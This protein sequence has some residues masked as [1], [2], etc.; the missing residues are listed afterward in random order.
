[1]HNPFNSEYSVKPQEAL[2]HP[3]LA[4]VNSRSNDIQQKVK[5]Q[6]YKG[7]AVDAQDHKR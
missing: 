5:E 2:F 7:S 1:M 6:V 4:R 3:T